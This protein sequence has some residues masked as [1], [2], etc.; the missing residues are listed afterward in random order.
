M[1]A[2]TPPH[3][4][5]HSLSQQADSLATKKVHDLHVTTVTGR[6]LARHTHEV[7]SSVDANKPEIALNVR[8]M[9]HDRG[10]RK[11]AGAWDSTC[12]LAGSGT[13]S[14]VATVKGVKARSVGGKV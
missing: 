4:H 7:A 14:Y 10:P 12:S 11:G 5:P 13:G 1:R 3:P 2:R 8:L 9:R 6:L